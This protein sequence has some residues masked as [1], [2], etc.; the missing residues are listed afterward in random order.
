MET[1]LASPKQTNPAGEMNLETG[2]DQGEDAHGHHPV[3]EPFI[4]GKEIFL[5]DVAE[6]CGG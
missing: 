4:S 5:G 1:A 2:E 6:A 3:P